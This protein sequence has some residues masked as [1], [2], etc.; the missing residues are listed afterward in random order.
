[1]R[2]A[3]RIALTSEQKRELER[4]A[5][6]RRTEARLV[7]RARIVLLA[8]EGQTD[9]EIAERFGVVPRTAAR[10]RGRFLEAGVAGLVHDAPRPGRPPAISA[11]TVLAVI[12]KTTQQRPP[13]Q[14]H[15]STRS[16]AA[17]IGISE[18]QCAAYL[19]GARTEAASR[20]YVQA[21]QRS[22][23]RGEAGR[24]RRPLLEPARACASALA[25]REEP[26][27]SAGSYPAG[28][29]P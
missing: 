23:L 25:R 14:T 20:P 16:M 6:G 3:A 7:V 13:H 28:L 1:M 29:A 19:A 12:E 4:F 8:A 2:V 21:E 11:E 26:D 27:S 18:S 22:A 9:L 10:W 15:W 24:C 17:A 5:R